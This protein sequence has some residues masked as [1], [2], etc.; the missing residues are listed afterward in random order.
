MIAVRTL[1]CF[2]FITFSQL[3]LVDN[4][5]PEKFGTPFVLDT[6]RKTDK[7]DDQH[8]DPLHEEVLPPGPGFS[9]L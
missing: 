1:L 9:N 3:T 8:P 4:L 2:M 7:Q 6:L 5:T